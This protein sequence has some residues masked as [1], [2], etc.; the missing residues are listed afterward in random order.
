MIAIGTQ[1]GKPAIYQLPHTA[2]TSTKRVYKVQYGGE[3]IVSDRWRAEFG[4]EIKNADQHFRIVYLTASPDAGDGEIAATLK[5]A[6]IVVCRPA[7]LSADTRDALG[8]LMAAEQMKR[9]ASAP[10]QTSL[11]EYA[12]TKR[13]E[14]VKDILKCQL[15]EFRRGKVLTQKDY[16]IPVAEIFK[17]SKE[18]EADLGGR[19]IEKAYDTPLFSPKDFKKDFTDADAKKVFA[20]LFHKDRANSEKDAV[21]NFGVGLELAVKS[22]P[23]EFKPEASQALARM[24]EHLSGRTDAPLAEL[25]AAFCKAPFGLTE[26]MVVLY[27]S[28]LV[29]A[30]GFELV[31][32]AASPVTLANEKP[33]PGNRLTTHALAL[34]DWNARLDKALLGARMVVSVQKGWNEVLPYARVLDDTLKTVATPDEEPQR[35]EQLLN[36]LGKLKAELPE[37]SK[38]LTTLAS[39]LGGIVPKS[40]TETCVRLTGL[41]ASASFQEFDAAVRESYPSREDFAKAFGPYAK[42]RQ[43]RDR[44]FDLSQVRDYLSGACDLDATVDTQRDLI[45]CLFKF[46]TLLADPAIIP[47]RLENFEKWKASYVQSYRKAHRAHHKKLTELETSLGTLKP[48]ARA[49][50]MMNTIVEIGPP[51]PTMHSVAADMAAIDKRL[52]VCPDAEHAAVEGAAPTCPKCSWT[53]L[54]QPAAAEVAKLAELVASGLADRFQRFKD[55]AI[56]T[57]LKK[58]AEQGDRPDL[59][60]LLEIVQLA[61][62]DAL[63]GVLTDELVDFLRKLLYDENLVQ[64]EIQLGPIVSDVGAIE[65]DHIDEAVDKFAKLLT[66]AVKDAK[67]KHG[68]SKRVRVFLRLQSPNGSVL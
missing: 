45:Q 16:G 31:L 19:L 32:N 20:G 44:A 60:K 12:E 42:G 43:L 25:K 13:R 8:G 34:C 59:T 58:A 57:I 4:E 56:S 1:A 48:K 39:K 7:A 17:F 67:A 64:E 38:S 11:R 6:R 24:R 61:N 40:L 50:V 33:L 55:A 27:A 23:T 3:V 52:Y 5:D 53:P 21:Q 54:D 37:V 22:N 65:E 68:K 28:S 29:K 51:L 10:N 35:N 47:V 9:N 26:A 66:K 63:A 46:D 41:A 36:I 18:R 49:L 14:A 15:D 62:S 2:A 30:G